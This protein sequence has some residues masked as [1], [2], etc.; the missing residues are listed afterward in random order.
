MSR[1]ANRLGAHWLA[2][3]RKQS[4]VQ[5]KT[6]RRR[7][8]LTM[9]SQTSLPVKESYGTRP[10]LTHPCEYSAG[11][12][13]VCRPLGGNGLLSKDLCKL[14]LFGSNWRDRVAFH[15]LH[16]V[17]DERVIT[18]TDSCLMEKSPNTPTFQKHKKEKRPPL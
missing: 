7:S 11:I 2:H 3:F 10:I 9:S 1:L 8:I 4:E 12:V 5:K 16:N 17:S 18:A 14:F 15:L 6:A 13:R